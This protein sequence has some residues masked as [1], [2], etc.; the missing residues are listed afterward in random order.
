MKWYLELC[1]I[2]IFF[3]LEMTKMDFSIFCIFDLLNYKIDSLHFTNILYTLYLVHYCKYTMKE[4]R[5]KV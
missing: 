5:D 1:K 2:K 3:F 4:D